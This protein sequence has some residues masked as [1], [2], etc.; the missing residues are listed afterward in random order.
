MDPDGVEQDLASDDPLDRAQV[1]EKKVPQPLDINASAGDKLASTTGEDR[2]N[3]REQRWTTITG[4]KR[5]A[6]RGREEEDTICG[7]FVS[8]DERPKT[9]DSTPAEELAL[10]PNGT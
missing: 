2:R 5:R 10:Q 8:F 9:P 3:G 4:R 6:S 7:L 1:L